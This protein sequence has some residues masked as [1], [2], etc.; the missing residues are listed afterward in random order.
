M[1]ESNI[2]SVG[3]LHQ[4]AKTKF[5]EYRKSNKQTN[6]QTSKIIAEVQ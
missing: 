1:F 4:N 2:T 6:K 3:M 5:T